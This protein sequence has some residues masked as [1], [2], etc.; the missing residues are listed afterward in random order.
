LFTTACAQSGGN[1]P[2]EFEQKAASGCK[3]MNFSTS[4]HV[5]R[6]CVRSAGPVK[7]LIYYFHGAGGDASDIYEG[8][9]NDLYKSLATH[10][11]ANVPAVVSVSFGQNETMPI[12]I[13]DADPVSIDELVNVAMPII[14]NSLGFD[15]EHVPVRNL[16]GLS[17]GGFNALNLAGERAES[18]RSVA[19]LC[20][21]LIDFDPFD[22]TQVDQ[23]IIRNQAVVSPD[24][25]NQ[26]MDLLRAKYTKAAIWNDN[27]PMNK[28]ES[29]KLASL[30]IFMSTGAAD[31][32]GFFEGANA[33]V[34]LAQPLN[35]QLVW[36][37]TSGEHCSFDSAALAKFLD[38]YVPQK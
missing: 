22:Q 33:F 7:S 1:G 15:S 9:F 3:N 24:L 12:E 26:T 2:T 27:D 10:F 23:Y 37:P 29:G 6:Y 30:P 32:Y 25:V 16:M 21:A 11:G 35:K 5:L 19:A 14:E 13:Q 8:Q 34:R 31:E 36:A 38:N 20:P 17:L 28:I 18:F 4:Q